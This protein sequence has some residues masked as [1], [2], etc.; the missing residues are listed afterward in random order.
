MTNKKV[1]VDITFELGQVVRETG[2]QA[3]HL[4]SEFQSEGVPE[5]KLDDYNHGTTKEQTPCSI[6]Y[7]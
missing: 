6:L 7:H 5:K 3:I 2:K 4:G 1:T